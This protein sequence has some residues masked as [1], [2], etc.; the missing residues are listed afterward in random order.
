[1]L[2]SDLKSSL[3]YL[4]AVADAL[5]GGLLGAVTADV[6]DLTTVVALLTLGAVARH[7]SETATSQSLADMQHKE[8]CTKRTR[9][10]RS[11]RPAGAG[12]RSRH[13]SHPAAGRIHRPGC[14]SWQCGR[15]CRTC[16]CTRLS[17]FISR[18]VELLL[19][20]LPLLATTTAHTATV[21]AL[22]A[23][24]RTTAVHALARQVS[25]LATYHSYEHFVASQILTCNLQ[26]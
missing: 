3:P 11:D 26:R 5:V 2:S 23:L 22:A 21:A 17:A 15:P 1:M 24:L 13:R 14:S 8:H 20:H 4:A 9:C 12:H 10:S 19:D 25:G 18:G 6:T 7:V 16:N